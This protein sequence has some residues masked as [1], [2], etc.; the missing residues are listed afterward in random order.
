MNTTTTSV[1]LIVTHFVCK[2]FELHK[3]LV[4]LPT[5]FVYSDLKLCSQR[6]RRSDPIL[7]D[8]T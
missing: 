8:Q 5:N 4:G 2:S 3:N 6:L 1:N 7:G